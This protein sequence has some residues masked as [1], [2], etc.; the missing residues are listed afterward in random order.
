M[1]ERTTPRR[2]LGRGLGSLIPTG[3]LH[4]PG[5]RDGEGTRDDVGEQPS[6]W[7]EAGTGTDA[8]SGTRPGAGG[9]PAD[10]IGRLPQQP[11]PPPDQGKPSGDHGT[12]SGPGAADASQ[13]AA[14][15]GEPGTNPSIEGT[16]RSA[17]KE[18]HG[19]YFAELPVAA[20]S[21]NPRQPRQVFDE[22]AMAELVH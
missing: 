20:V 6:A 17:L 16:G 10:W 12:A 5:H 18:V 2:G 3:P 15:D 19:A 4:A 22:E 1:S 13:H 14:A 8:A 7:P 9:V 21:P 11:A